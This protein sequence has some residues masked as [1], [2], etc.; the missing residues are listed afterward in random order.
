M[1]DVIAIV[2][3]RMGKTRLPGKF[4]LYLANKPMLV[5]DIERIRSPKKTLL[6]RVDANLD[7]G[8]GHVMR[9]L[10]IAQVW[11]DDGGIVTFLMAPGS[12]S[13]E[14]RICSEGMNVLTITERP[15]SDEDATITVEIAKKIESSWIVVDGYQFGATYQKILKTHNFKVFFIDDYGHAD[16]YYADIVLNQNIYA[17]MSFYKNYEQYTRFL[18]GSNFVLLRREFLNMARYNRKIPEVARKV[19]ITFGGADPD[20]ITL[21]I[22]EAL[23]KIEIDALELIAVVGGVNPNYET[24]KQNVEGHPSFLIRKNV[25]NMPEL[26]AWAD[27]AISAGGSTC[28]ELA[29]SG[30]PNIIIILSDDQELIAAELSKQGVSITLGRFGNTNNTSIINVIS[31]LILSPKKRYTMSQTGRRIV[32]GNGAHRVISALKDN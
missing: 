13:L 30:L 31:E 29:F 12:P 20:N 24:L 6:I 27:V 3:N 18:L 11:Q 22:I 14:Q 32:D 8:A 16:H 5:R 2:Q 10:A 15:G 25:E 26:M 1:N 17:N 7:I 4:F 21:N 19:L 9:C 23:K 28:W